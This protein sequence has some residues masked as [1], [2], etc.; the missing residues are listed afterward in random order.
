MPSYFPRQSI[1]WA[2]VEE[3]PAFRRLSLSLV[4]MALLTGVVL[5]LL[6]AVTYSMGRASWLVFGL[7]VLVGVVLLVGMATA[8]LANFSL[9]RWLWRAPAFALVTTAAAM[10]TSLLLIA[11]HREPEGTARAHFHDWPGMAVRFLLYSELTVCAWALVL[12]GVILLIRRSGMARR[13]DS[14]ETIIL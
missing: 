9:R 10:A 7:A 5:R 6:R 4:E 1:D 2:S 3:P 12:A 13:R 8:H 14:V 11:V